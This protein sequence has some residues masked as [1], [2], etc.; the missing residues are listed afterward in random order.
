MYEQIYQRD[1]NK[2]ITANIFLKG[3]GKKYS[4]VGSKKCH[5]SSYVLMYELKVWYIFITL[6]FNCHKTS[7]VIKELLY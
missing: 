1:I 6:L 2:N 4:F 5:Y 7:K 3:L